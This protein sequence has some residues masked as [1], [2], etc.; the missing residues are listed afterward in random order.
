MPNYNPINEHAAYLKLFWSEYGISRKQ[1]IRSKSETIRG[2]QMAGHVF[3]YYSIK[4]AT[5][6]LQKKMMQKSREKFDRDKD[7]RVRYMFQKGDV[8][9]AC[10]GTPNVRHH[11]IWLK[12]GGRN[13]KRNICFLCF[14]CHA[15]IH[16][17]L[18]KK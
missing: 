18:K 12:N 15:E 17:W 2:L 13:C 10:G 8:C 14:S 9:F 1:S 5:F 4:G 11:I 16:P 7:R 6:E 3:I